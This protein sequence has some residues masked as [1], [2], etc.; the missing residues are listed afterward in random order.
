MSR[1]VGGLKTPPGRPVRSRVRV[2]HTVGRLILYAVLYG[3]AISMALPFLWMLSTSL[4]ALPD[5]F[6]WPPQLLPNPPL[7]ENYAKVFALVP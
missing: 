1:I 5:V 3:G 2:G 7:W 6:K 4:K